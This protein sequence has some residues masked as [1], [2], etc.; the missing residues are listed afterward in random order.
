MGAASVF[1]MHCSW[2]FARTPLIWPGK[3]LRL[4]HSLV[5]GGAARWSAVSAARADSLW[6]GDFLPR[7]PPLLSPNGATDDSPGHR[8]GLYANMIW[9]PEGAGQTAGRQSEDMSHFQRSMVLSNGFPA[10]ACRPDGACGMLSSTSV[11]LPSALPNS[12]QLPL[13]SSHSLI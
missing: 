8:P 10:I 2:N 13:Q 1:K 7:P 5:D 4:G 6:S 3:L 11:C 12:R 9:S